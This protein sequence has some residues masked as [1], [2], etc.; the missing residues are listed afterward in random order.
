MM[1]SRH[2]GFWLAIMVTATLTS[3]GTTATASAA[4]R[5]MSDSN[6]A[7]LEVMSR[8]CDWQID[9]LPSGEPKTWIYATLYAGL[10][11]AYQTTGHSRYLD[12][13]LT[14]AEAN[15]WS[16]GSR[17]R[18]AD[19]HCAGQ[20][21][22]ELYGLENAPERIE[23]TQR[24]LD[25]MMAEPRSGR[26]DWWWCDALFM[27]PPVLARLGAATGENK[28]FDFLSDMW[29]DTTDFLFDPDEGLFYRDAN[30]FN[31]RCPNGQKMF[32]SRG[33]GWV[34]AGIVR[35]LQYLPPDHPDRDRF[36]V[37]L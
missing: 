20:T 15:R 12:R 37:L 11:A 10:M 9:N 30:Y 2:R 34:I 4:E 25:A 26:E 7:V 22:L 33:N 31:R 24:V 6:E 16:L 28:Y 36:V 29:W 32:W 18:H 17:R 8:V 3:S 23:P 35:V 14:W 19:D 27:A 21:Y 1:K 13:A 5:R